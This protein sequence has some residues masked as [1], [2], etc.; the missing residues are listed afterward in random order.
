[1]NIYITRVADMLERVDRYIVERAIIPAIAR[2]TSDCP[3]TD[4][5]GVSRTTP[6]DSGAFEAP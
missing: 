5:R 6:C 3:L 1:M 2:V 4:Q